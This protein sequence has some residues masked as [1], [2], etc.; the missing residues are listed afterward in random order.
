MN[1]RDRLI[2]EITAYISGGHA[3]LAVT[4]ATNW[5]SGSTPEKITS[6]IEELFKR[7]EREGIG[8][9][10]YTSKRRLVGGFSIEN[11]DRNAHVHGLVRIPKGGHPINVYRLSSL[12]QKHWTTMVGGGSVQ[13]EWAVNPQGWVG[14]MSKKVTHLTSS[15]FVFTSQFWPA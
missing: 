1:Y 5:V 10:F 7:V 12:L 11:M 4:L 2:D 13:T 14:Y 6:L 8:R 9:R 3:T 15:D